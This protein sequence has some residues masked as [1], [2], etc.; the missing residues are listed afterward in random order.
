TNAHGEF[1]HVNYP[2]VVC[3]T[4]NTPNSCTGENEIVRLSDSTNA[5]AEDPELTPH[6]YNTPACYQGLVSCQLTT[7]QCDSNSEIEMLTLSSPINAHIGSI[8]ASAGAYGNRV[9][10]SITQDATNGSGETPTAPGVYWV[11][12]YSGAEI[13]QWNVY[14]GISE[15][16]MSL[17]GLGLTQGTQVTF[18]IYENDPLVDDNIRTGANA[19]TGTA[20]ANGDV[21]TSWTITQDDLDKTLDDYTQF[22]FIATGT[23]VNEQSDYLELIVQGELTCTGIAACLNYQEEGI[24]QADLCGVANASVPEGI[25]CTNPSISCFCTWDS[26]DI[27]GVCGSQWN[28]LDEQGNILGSCEYTQDAGGDDCSDGFLSYSWTASWNGGGE[29][30]ENN[31][32]NGQKTAE[33]PA[34]IALPFFNG[35]NLLITILVIASI[36]AVLILRDKHKGRKNKK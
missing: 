8:G 25:D 31:C 27:E 4:F 32:V 19:I 26:S 7:S 20:N 36:Y 23:G 18:E 28:L 15:V 6:N 11:S 12:S 29:S 9:C 14:T 21:M 30:A 34:Q 17:T 1:P 24:C 33:C 22:Y 35:Y 5:H 10:C 16:N 3:C 2:D 13:T